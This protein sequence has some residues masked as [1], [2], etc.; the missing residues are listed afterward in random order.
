LAARISDQLGHADPGFTLRT[1]I[2]RDP[3]G[4]KADLAATL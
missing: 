4:D 1:Y 3:D 2:G